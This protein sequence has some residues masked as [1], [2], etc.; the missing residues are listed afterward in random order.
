MCYEDN[1]D[2]AE[3]FPHVLSVAAALLLVVALLCAAAAAAFAGIVNG[4][5]TSAPVASSYCTLSSLGSSTGLSGCTTGMAGAPVCIFATATGTNVNWR[6]DGTAAT[7]VVGTGGQQLVAGA[8]M[9]YCGNL[10]NLRFIEQTAS[11][12]LSVGFYK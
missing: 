12:K 6:D 7:A 4:I 1:T 5:T 9:W 8:S 11:A 2:D 10:A 3:C